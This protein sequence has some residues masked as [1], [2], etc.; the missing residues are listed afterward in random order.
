MLASA[1]PV[2][3][4]TCLLALAALRTREAGARSNRNRLPFFHFVRQGDSLAICRD[5]SDRAHPGR[6]QVVPRQDVNRRLGFIVQR[7]HRPVRAC[8]LPPSSAPRCTRSYAL[9]IAAQTFNIRL[10]Q[11]ATAIRYSAQAVVGALLTAV[12]LSNG[13]GKSNILDAICFVLG[14]Q[15][16]TT[17]RV[18]RPSVQQLTGP[19]TRPESARPHLQAGS[20]RCHPRQRHH[21]L[22]QLGQG[23]GP[24]RIRGLE[25]DFSHASGQFLIPASALRAC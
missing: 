15:N 3:P 17:V 22:Q 10:V 4:R 6:V 1:S 14:I 20:G 13:S 19:G 24:R 7:D 12:L 16:L 11:H 25:R 9:A 18:P 21:R 8:S 5:E 23:Q 2:A